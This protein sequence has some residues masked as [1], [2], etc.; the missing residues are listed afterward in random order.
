MKEIR[1][2]GPVQ[3]IFRVYSDFFLYSTGIYSRHPHA[4]TLDDQ[5][6]Y[7]SVNVFGWNF[8]KNGMPYWVF[9][10]LFHFTIRSL[11]NFVVSYN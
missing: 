9:I 3:M 2:N 7:H 10:I 6:S 8:T 11:Q 1:E 5:V 4:K